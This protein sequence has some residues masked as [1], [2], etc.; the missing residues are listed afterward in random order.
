[1]ETISFTA[2][3][4]EA[5]SRRHGMCSVCMTEEDSKNAAKSVSV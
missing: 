5:E 1:L 2:I 3:V 4:K